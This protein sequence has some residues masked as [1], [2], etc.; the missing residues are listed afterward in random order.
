MRWLLLLLQYALMWAELAFS[1]AVAK[2]VATM[3]I[4]PS[5]LEALQALTLDQTTQWL[6][7]IGWTT[8]FIASFIYRMMSVLGVL[9]SKCDCKIQYTNKSY[10][11]A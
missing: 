1:G 9:S 5:S 2:A 3:G 7:A 10:Y 4:F 6:G 11:I 8:E